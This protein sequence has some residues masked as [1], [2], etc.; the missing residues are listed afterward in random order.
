MSH[1]IILHREAIQVSSSSLHWAQ[2]LC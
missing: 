2:Q 1:I